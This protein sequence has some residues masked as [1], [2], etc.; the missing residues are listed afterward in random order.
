MKLMNTAPLRL[1]HGLVLAGM[2]VGLFLT[3]CAEI[4]RP[5]TPASE[6]PMEATV[7]L[8]PAPPTITPAP[9]QITPASPAS[10]TPTLT[11][12][13][14]STPFPTPTQTPV[15]ASSPTT[16][17]VPTLATSPTPEPVTK[18]TPNIQLQ[19]KIET[20]TIGGSSD[21]IQR[22]VI[23]SIDGL[24][25]DAWEQADTPILDALRLKGAFTDVAQTVVP[26][27]TLIAHA[28]MLGGMTPEKHGIYWNVYDPSLGLI[29]GPTLFSEAHNAGLRTA[30]VAGKP[31][32]AHI[33]LPN[34]VDNYNYA[35]YTDQQTVEAALAVIQTGLPDVLFIHLPNVDS[36]GHAAGWMSAEQLTTV[37]IA[38][39]LVGELVAA[40]DAGGY[41]PGTLLVITAD[42]GGHG[43]EH[44]D[45]PEDIIVP[46]LAVGPGVPAGLTLQ[47]GLMI[48]DTAATALY[49]LNLPIPPT[50]DGRPVLE[51]FTGK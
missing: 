19:Q 8:P 37:S 24:R 25:P 7:S 43:F 2:L 9:S 13:P 26:A 18:P 49:A 17:P 31:R 21:D 38:D 30:M 42:H 6:V 46:W 4:D 12:S 44:G 33:V 5:G 3:G 20:L 27:T 23:I 22:V 45:A 48:Y 15:A 39:G 32:L 51:I 10:A 36:V 47:P 28:S 14:T 35:G 1:K 50:W 16:T 11:A 34:S 41:L 40:I 29:N